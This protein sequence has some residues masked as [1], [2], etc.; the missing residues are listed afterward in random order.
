MYPEITIKITMRPEGVQVS[1]EQSTAV[2]G[3]FSVPAV[4]TQQQMAEDEEYAV[5]SIGNEEMEVIEDYSIP[6]VPNEDDNAGSD[7]EYSVPAISVFQ[8]EDIED[9]YAIPVPSEEEL[10]DDVEVPNA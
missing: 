5:P 9:E 1:Q 2:T 4:P 8:E 10:G 7:E 3:E 6:S